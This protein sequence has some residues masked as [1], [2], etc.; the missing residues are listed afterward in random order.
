MYVVVDHRPSVTDGYTATFAR[1]G[2]PAQGFDGQEFGEWLNTVSDEDLDAV[3]GFVLGD[4]D[5]RKASPATIR[6]R[7]RAPI[8]ALSENRSLE[9]TLELYQTGIDDVVG[10]PV[11]VTELVVRADAVWRRV[12]QSAS[13]GETG[14]IKVFLDGRDPEV[15]G[16]SLHLPRREHRILVYLAKN[17]H[18]R[19]TKTQIFNAVYG[20]FNDK[21]DEAAIEGHISKLR[22]KIRQRVGRDVIN[23]KRFLGYQFVG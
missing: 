10:K 5:G 16:E 9:Q 14:Q 22:K 23:A 19:L 18:R 3:T 12:H 20:M 1:E 6:R 15:N 2:F 4:F 17:A 7:S 11:H 8:I 21:T 13:N